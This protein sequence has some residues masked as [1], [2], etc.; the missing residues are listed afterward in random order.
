MSARDMLPP[1]LMTSEPGSFAQ[2]T[3]LERLPEIAGQALDGDE[4]PPKLGHIPSH[5]LIVPRCPRP[6]A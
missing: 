4:Y 6:S 1:P 3:M 2:F 5:S